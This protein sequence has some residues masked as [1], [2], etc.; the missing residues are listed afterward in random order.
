MKLDM[1]IIKLDGEILSP[2]AAGELDQNFQRY[3]PPDNLEKPHFAKQLS[4]YT[5]NVYFARIEGIS[6]IGELNPL[7]VRWL[8]NHGYRIEKI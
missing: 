8:E 4:S 2:K 5:A 3:Y 6:E 1:Q 7:L